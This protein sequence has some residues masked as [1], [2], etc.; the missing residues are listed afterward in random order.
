MALATIRDISERKKAEIKIGNLNKQLISAAKVAGMAEIAN[1]VLHNLGNVLN[2][3]NTSV[4]VLLQEIGQSGFFRKFRQLTDLLNEHMPTLGEYLTHDEKGKLLPA[5]LVKLVDTSEKKQRKLIGEIQCLH[6]TLQ[7]A[8]ELVSKQHALSG[9]SAII[10][11][12]DPVVIL[13]SALKISNMDHLDILVERDIDAI[14]MIN[15]DQSK[16]LQILVSL[17]VNANESLRL[18]S[19]SHKFISVSIKKIESDFVSISV[20]DNGV[21][22]SLENMNRVFSFGFSTKKEGHGF[23]LHTAY[24]LAKEL[25][26]T[27]HVK[28]DG[29][30]HGATF[31]LLLPLVR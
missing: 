4:G 6:E 25:G 1:A 29:S 28:S 27:L 19:H 24:L 31:A 21:G 8:L 10:E 2:S 23:G 15:T 17:L 13:E 11:E 7:I 18:S 5:Y 3:M 20:R 22:I 12:T 9:I 26:G 14:P 30:G 16:L